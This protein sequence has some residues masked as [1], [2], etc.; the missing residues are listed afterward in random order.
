MRKVIQILL[1]VFFVSG[2]FIGKALAAVGVIVF[3]NP[4]EKIAKVQRTDDG[5]LREYV[6]V[7][8]FDLADPVNY[9]PTVGDTVGFDAERGRRASDVNPK[10]K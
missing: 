10:A 4:S 6:I 3:V 9:T 5:T 1:T 8:P 7:S 2:M